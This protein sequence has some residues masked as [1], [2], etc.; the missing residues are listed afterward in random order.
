MDLTFL[1]SSNAFAS[2]G[3]YWSSFLVDGKY[4][5]DAPPT[6]L[7][8]LK[9]LKVPVTDIQVIFLTHFHADHFAGLPFL[10]LEYVYMTKR[11]QDLFIVGPPGV[12]E[13]MEDF[14]NRCYEDITRDVG[15]RRRY[16]EAAAGQEQSAG[17]LTFR[18]LT[19]NHKAHGV[20]AMGYRVKIGGNTVAY[21]GDTMYCDEIVELGSD[22]DVLVMDCTYTAGGSGPEHMS[23]DDARAVRKRLTPS[24]AI[25]LT[26]MNGT[27]IT[28]GLA[29]VLKAEDL[30]TFHF[31]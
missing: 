7:P 19:M 1:G 12:Q 22:A 25:I 13:R 14:A 6:L 17:P 29:N 4:Q 30:K 31:D 18:A 24:T 8:H 16:V 26:H 11:T 10:F 23:L 20:P 5:F 15:Y 9:Q 3:R 27:P 21:T 28:N 2:E